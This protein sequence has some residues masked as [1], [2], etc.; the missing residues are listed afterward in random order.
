MSRKSRIGVVWEKDEDEQLLKQ[1]SDSVPLDEIAKDH[2]RTE[3]CIKS[4]LV[5]LALGMIRTGETIETVS[6]KTG[7]TVDEI[8]LGHKSPVEPQ[9]QPPAPAEDRFM[10]ILIDIRNIIPHTSSFNIYRPSLKNQ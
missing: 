2:K 7:L 6:K 1:I 3:K 4:R 5:S 9:N 8:K 10:A